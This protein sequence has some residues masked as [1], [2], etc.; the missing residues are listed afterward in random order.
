MRVE[1][2]VGIVVTTKGG[3]SVLIGITQATTRL[4]T[5]VVK[6]AGPAVPLADYGFEVA[7][8]NLGAKVPSSFERILAAADLADERIMVTTFDLDPAP[9]VAEKLS[10]V[11]GRDAD[12]AIVPTSSV[13]EPG[14]G[15][16]LAMGDATSLV[17]RA[18]FSMCRHGV[19]C[20]LVTCQG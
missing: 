17:V 3:G 18:Q 19:G 5:A 15:P 13:L 9:P 8:R 16:A 1:R 14:M 7:E 11:V 4:D 20:T 12:D 2:Y 6:G 10:R